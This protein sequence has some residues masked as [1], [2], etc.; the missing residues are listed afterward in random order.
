MGLVELSRPMNHVF[1]RE[2][3]VVGDYPRHSKSRGGTAHCQVATDPVHQCKE[4]RRI[5]RAL[6]STG[7]H[8]ER[9]GRLDEKIHARVVRPS[10]DALPKA[11]QAHHL[12][13]EPI[14]TRDLVT[15]SGDAAALNEPLRG[16]TRQC[17]SLA[18]VSCPT[19]FPSVRTAALRPGELGQVLDLELSYASKSAIAHRG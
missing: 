11:G 2:P 8:I 14:G 6:T 9:I 15:V 18:P 16:Y 1:L 7:C 17:R 4:A 5:F 12:A 13:S 19:A 10:H 3:G